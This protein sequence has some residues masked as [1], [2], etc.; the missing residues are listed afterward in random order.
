[1]KKV[2]R[3]IVF[4]LIHIVLG[5]VCDIILIHIVM[6]TNIIKY[7]CDTYPLLSPLM[8]SWLG[9]FC[10]ILIT[11]IVINPVVYLLTVRLL[12]FNR[13]K[14]YRLKFAAGIVG[15]S[16]LTFLA[17]SSPLLVLFIVYS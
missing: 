17:A 10:D 2:W 6:L 9:V 1:M 12:K 11:V 14:Y 5:L 3:Y 7:I 4:C 13:N 15:S 8:N 16:L